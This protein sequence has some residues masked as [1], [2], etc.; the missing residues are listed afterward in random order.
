MMTGRG[1]GMGCFSPKGAIV[2]GHVPEIKNVPNEPFLSEGLN[3]D[4]TGSRGGIF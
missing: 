4:R 2:G 1:L 3:D